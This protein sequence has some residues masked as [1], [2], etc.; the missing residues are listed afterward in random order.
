MKSKKPK[1]AVD[2]LARIYDALDAA[3]RESEEEVDALLRSAGLN[4]ENV[5]KRFR[6][7]AEATMKRTTARSG[8]VGEKILA[9]FESFLDEASQILSV[10]QLATQTRSVG[11]EQEDTAMLEGSVREE[12]RLALYLVFNGQYEQAKERFTEL[13]Q[14][15]SDWEES[16]LRWSFHHVLLRQGQTDEAREQLEAL[17]D[18]DDEYG[19]RARRRLRELDRL[20]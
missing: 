13:I 9:W 18:V 12:H 16:W 19:D 11:G 7:L 1:T 2:K 14:H 4:P 15:A 5:E 8:D 10:G 17:V 3:P 6:N 20:N